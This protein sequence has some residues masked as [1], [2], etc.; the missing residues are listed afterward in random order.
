MRFEPRTGTFGPYEVLY[1]PEPQPEIAWGP[2][3]DGTSI[4][5]DPEIKGSMGRVY[6]YVTP[7]LEAAALVDH[8]RM[9]FDHPTAWTD[10]YE[11]YIAD[12]LFGEVTPGDPPLAGGAPFEGMA[13][14]AKC[15]TYH[16]ASEALWRLNL[17]KVR[18]AFDFGELVKLLKTA[19]REDGLPM[20]KIY[21][22]R[23]RYMEGPKIRQELLR[24]RT[25]PQEKV[26]RLAVPAL[27]MK[28]V[29]FHFENEIRICI[30][31]PP[32]EPVTKF[33]E[34]K[35]AGNGL[36]E[37]MI[38]PYTDRPTALALADRFYMRGFKVHQSKFNLDPRAL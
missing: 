2:P 14:Y 21:I 6:R 24:L 32:G 38:N 1:V 36:K 16:Y 31:C 9:R 18:L 3:L 8:H 28:R 33:L 17:G 35:L 29:G 34:L 5:V 4:Y 23:A 7:D 25:E 37:L 15:V 26:S 13:I 19:K 27:L 30:V 12:N 20:P 10:K 22:G 11:T